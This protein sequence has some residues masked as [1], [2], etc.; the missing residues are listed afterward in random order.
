[1]AFSIAVSAKPRGG[2]ILFPLL[3]CSLR[4]LQLQR[5]L[6][7]RKII[8]FTPRSQPAWKSAGC[9]PLMPNVMQ[10]VSRKPS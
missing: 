10:G 6:A 9:E 7:L 5:R 2:S 4:D 3:Q 1:M 8:L